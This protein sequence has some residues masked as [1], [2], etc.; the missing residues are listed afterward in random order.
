MRK[1]SKLVMVAFVA[2]ALTVGF[3]SCEEL[4]TSTTGTVKVVNNTGSSIVADVN[5]GIGDWKGERTIY[6]GS[7]ATWTGCEEGSIDCSARYTGQT[8][9]FH[10]STRTLVAGGTV[11]ITWQ[12]TKKSATIENSI[13]LEF[14]FDGT[15]FEP[16]LTSGKINK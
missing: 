15:I 16:A 13:P 12:R 7:T 2:I 8:N 9:W 4:V 6:S 11:T 1:I 3:S 5:D 10:S 14:S